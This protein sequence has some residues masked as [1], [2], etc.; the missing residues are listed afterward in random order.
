MP[1]QNYFHDCLQKKYGDIANLNAQWHT[2]Y[3]D[4]AAIAI[5]EVKRRQG[6]AI[7]VFLDPAKD[8]D[9]IEFNRAFSSCVADFITDLAADCFVWH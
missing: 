7:Q 2:S 6:S 9:I 1:M 4:F 8:Q 3:P 5:P